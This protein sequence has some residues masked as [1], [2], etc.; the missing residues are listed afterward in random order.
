MG[1]LAGLEQREEVRGEQR[2]DVSR[3][4]RVGDPEQVGVIGASA[5]RGAFMAP[6]LLLTEDPDRASR[7]RSR[8]S[9]R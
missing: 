9:G 3:P 5:E 2:P 8:P 4:G 1:A 7:T 6:M